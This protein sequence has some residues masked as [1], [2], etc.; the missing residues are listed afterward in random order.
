MEKRPTKCIKQKPYIGKISSLKP[1]HATVRKPWDKVAHT[2]HSLRLST[3][4]PKS[5]FYLCL[6][7]RN[8]M[9]GPFIMWLPCRRRVRHTSERTHFL[10]GEAAED[11]QLHKKWFREMNYLLKSSVASALLSYCLEKFGWV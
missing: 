7:Y 2:V 9:K 3:Y 6:L 8:I 11:T 4:I 10:L 1:R 5:W